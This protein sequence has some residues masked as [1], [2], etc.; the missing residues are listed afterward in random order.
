MKTRWIVILLLLLNCQT[1]VAAEPE[2]EPQVVFLAGGDLLFTSNLNPFIKSKGRDYPFIGI[3]KY[4][5]TADVVFAN[6]EIPLTKNTEPIPDKGYTYRADPVWAKVLARNGFNLLTIANNHILD[7]GDKGLLDTLKVLREEGIHFS[8]AGENVKQARKAAVL[9]VKGLKIAC[10]SYSLTFPKEFYAQE[11]KPGTAFAYTEFLKEDIPAARAI[12]DIVIVSCH[13]S[14]E[15]LHMPKDYQ[16][17]L[18]HKMIDLGADMILGHHPHIIQGLEIYKGKPIAYSLGNLA[19]STYSR[20]VKDS[21]LLRCRLDKQSKVSQLEII[22][23]SVDNFK[24]RFQ[25]K[26]LSGKEAYELLCHLDELSQPLGAEVIVD[27][28][29]GRISE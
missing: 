21:M 17:K 11:D 22:P 3:K 19:F 13:W 8:G 15:L 25:P 7:Y 12:A 27:G 6:L 28:D 5:K 18:A 14:G 4:L 20:S 26:P 10:L 23:L 2:P 16:R 1:V 24:I 29:I 9:T